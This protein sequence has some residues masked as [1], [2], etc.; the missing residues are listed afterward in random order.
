M[1]NILMAL[2][3]IGTILFLIF[4]L[5]PIQKIFAQDSNAGFVPGNI[6]YS[7]DPFEEGDKIK[8]YTLIFNPDE[9]ELSGTVIFFDSSVFLG[10][11]D[12][13]ASAKGIKDVSIDW[14]AT[15]GDHNIFGKIEN[16]RFLVSGE[17]S[18]R[19]Y[20]DVYLSG[21]E[22]S[23][24]SRRVN[25]KIVSVS[26]DTI[27]T[28]IGLAAENTGNIVGDYL[29]NTKEAAGV[30]MKENTPSVVIKPIALAI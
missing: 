12:F 20:E 11:K 28:N 27:F 8:I 18:E 22:T 16:S 15:V 23:K 19:T 24:S 1:Y 2:K 10:K 9:R 14:T 21:N 5:L 7:Q 3:K 6:W 17:K 13:T 26:S 30:A 25:K 29:K 4:S